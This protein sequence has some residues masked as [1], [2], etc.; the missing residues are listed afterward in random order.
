[1][2]ILS[3]VKVYCDYS[4][5]EILLAKKCVLNNL[6]QPPNYDIPIEKE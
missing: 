2:K 5:K 3:D 1:M 6:P 4:D